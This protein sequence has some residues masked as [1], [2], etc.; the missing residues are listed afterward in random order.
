MAV[1]LD[2]QTGLE[3][4]LVNNKLASLVTYFLIGLSREKYPFPFSA[5]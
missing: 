5:I 1:P 2:N 3:K 4:K